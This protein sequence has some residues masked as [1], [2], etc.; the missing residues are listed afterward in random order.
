MQRL[1]GAVDDVQIHRAVLTPG[2]ILAMADKKTTPHAVPKPIEPFTLWTGGPLPKGADIP[3]L[4]D[5]EHL[6]QKERPCLHAGASSSS[7]CSITLW[8]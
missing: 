3:V 5:V 8:Q 2:E 6:V 7:V 4:E 1:Q